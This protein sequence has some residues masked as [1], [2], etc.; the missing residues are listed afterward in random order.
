MCVPCSQGGKAGFVKGL[1][2]CYW[3][4]DMSED[5]SHHPRNN[6]GGSPNSSV[7]GADVGGQAPHSRSATA[8]LLCA[9][10]TIVRTLGDTVRA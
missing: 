9:D 1:L 8:A 4:A 2:S 3:G 5:E 10:R 6:D 7:H